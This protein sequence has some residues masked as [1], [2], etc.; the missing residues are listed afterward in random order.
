M[1][2]GGDLL[3]RRMRVVM[4]AQAVMGGLA[5]AGGV[6]YLHHHDGVTAAAFVL[7]LAGAAAVL[8]IHVAR[9]RRRAQAEGS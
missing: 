4:G 5:T 3:R 6:L 8:L 1:T 9:L 2:P 7:P